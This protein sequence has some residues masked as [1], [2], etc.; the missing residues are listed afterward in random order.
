M[1]HKDAARYLAH[2]RQ[3]WRAV[4]AARTETN[5]PGPETM[6]PRCDDV[7]CVTRRVTCVTGRVTRDSKRRE[8]T[9]RR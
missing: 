9:R 7:T 3:T 5:A 1:A 4:T 8:K 2:G 6:P